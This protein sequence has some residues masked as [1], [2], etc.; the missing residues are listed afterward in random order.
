[1]RFVRSTLSVFAGEVTTH[2]NGYCT[3]GRR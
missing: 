2:L 1:V 3:A